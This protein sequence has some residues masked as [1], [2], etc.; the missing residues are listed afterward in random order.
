MG[1]KDIPVYLLL[2]SFLLQLIRPI[3][4]NFFQKLFSK[5]F[6]IICKNKLLNNIQLKTS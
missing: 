6:L 2:K 4:E 3:S 1:E 5:V